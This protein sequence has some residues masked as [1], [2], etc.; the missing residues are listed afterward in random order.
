MSKIMIGEILS[1]KEECDFNPR[2]GKL[3]GRYG[4]FDGKVIKS[5]KYA[6]YMP[7]EKKGDSI[8]PCINAQAGIFPYKE[9]KKT[10]GKIRPAILVFG[11]PKN[12]GKRKTHW[13]D[14]F[15]P[16]RGYIKYFGDNK[17]PGKSPETSNNNILMKAYE[18]HEDS[19]KE[20]RKKAPP[21]LFFENIDTGI[22]KFQG[23]GV[24][25]KVEL[26]SQKHSSGQTF[27][28]YAFDFVVLNTREENE[29]FDWSWI[30]DRRNSSLTTNQMLKKAPKSWREW[31]NNEK[32]IEN[33][34]RNVNTI[35][36]QPTEKQ[37]AKNINKKVL[38]DIY[39]YYYNNK[40]DFE[41]LAAHSCKYIIDKYS[42]GW[43]TKQSGDG[44]TDF[45][46]RI[47]LGS[48]GV[49][50]MKIITLGQAKCIKPDAAINAE[51]IARVVARL[52]RGWVGA[53][54]TTGVFRE[55]AQLELLNDDYPIFLINGKEVSEVVIKRMIKNGLNPSFT[56]D[57]Y[58]Y[59]ETIKPKYEI[60]NRRPE[61][62]LYN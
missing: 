1:N 22:Y 23:F 57:T 45:V 42:T 33:I 28:N 51:N 56:A 24:I 35:L 7:R 36:V 32:K 11:H 38:D 21:I 61:E 31:V 37:K 39:N 17:T 52:K 58:K 41:F 60:L 27:T 55:K 6:T 10:D 2:T 25:N 49:L 43:I 54:V 40:H 53:Y 12:A 48:S 3:S 34:R 19:D 26:L 4:S 13:K 14:I 5:L 59:L 62:I 46:G 47:N 20:V 50:P 30:N 9:I 8:N 15:E 29:S 44:G 18:M 16:D